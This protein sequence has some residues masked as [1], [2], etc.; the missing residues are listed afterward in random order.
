MTIETINDNSESFDYGKSLKQGSGSFIDRIAV[1]ERYINRPLASLIVR[2][3]FKTPVTPNGLTYF[4]FLVGLV[5]AFFIS[6]G[7][8]ADF[9]VGG[10]LT[11][12][13]AI[14]DCA[15]GQLARAKDI[16]SKFGS[17]LDLFLDRITDFALIVGASVG[18]Y[19]FYDDSNL[20]LLGLLGS[21]LYLLQI[22][23]YYIT[24]NYKNDH[25]HGATGEA[26]AMFLLLV[27]IFSIAGRLDIMIYL[28]IV[29]TA[30]VN[31]VRIIHFVSLGRKNNR[32]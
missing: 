22:N 32:E 27:L 20:L 6:R 12:L 15:D 1:V 7:T 16:C 10:V 14:I 3:V 13:S 25:K 24:K 23:L 4:S 18:C 19:R 26:R 31:A 9:V 5:G 8:Y 28:L 11:Q 30:L 29:E 2:A 17:Y 21:G